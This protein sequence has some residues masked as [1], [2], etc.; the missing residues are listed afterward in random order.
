MYNKQKITDLISK[1]GKSY[2]EI[3]KGTKIS[4]GMIGKFA[5]GESSPSVDYL[6]IL[7]EYFG[8]SIN[9]F[10]TSDIE[11]ENLDATWKILYEKQVEITNL[12]LEIEKLK[13]DFRE[14]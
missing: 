9:Y 5:R 14:K 11:D 7:A 12:K 2:N 1:S 4:E 6:A 13:Q 10:F 8:K 3:S